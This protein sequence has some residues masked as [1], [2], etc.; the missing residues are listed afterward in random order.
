[1]GGLPFTELIRQIVFDTFPI[2]RTEDLTGPS[3]T[4][5]VG[6]GL[7]YGWEIVLV[8]QLVYEEYG[9]AF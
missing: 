7:R 5:C 2:K 4:G 9:N 3:Q 8:R 1:M 6:D